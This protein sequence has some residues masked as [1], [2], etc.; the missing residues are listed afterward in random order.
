MAHDLTKKHVKICL[1]LKYFTTAF[2]SL[3]S[4]GYQVRLLFKYNNLYRN[5]F[6]IVL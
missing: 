3:A 4:W 5:N 6:Q 2:T 1:K